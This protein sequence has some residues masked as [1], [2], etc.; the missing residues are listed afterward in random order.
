MNQYLLCRYKKNIKSTNVSK[1]NKWEINAFKQMHIFI[2]GTVIYVTLTL[3][4]GLSPWN[5]STDIEK[6]SL[7]VKMILRINYPFRKSKL[8]TYKF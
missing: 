8:I 7:Q 6:T 2:Q 4:S 3:L 1:P 5:N